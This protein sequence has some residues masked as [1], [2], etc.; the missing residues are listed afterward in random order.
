AKLSSSFQKR[1]LL[2]PTNTTPPGAVGLSE[3]AA[4]N[5]AIASA[6]RPTFFSASFAT[7]GV[8]SIPN[9]VSSNTHR[10]MMKSPEI[11]NLSAWTEVPYNAWFAPAPADSPASRKD[12]PTDARIRYRHQRSPR[13]QPPRC[14]RAASPE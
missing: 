3:S 12:A 6:Q 10:N 5:L 7:P 14:G 1:M 8:D 13:T 11:Q 4:V 2:L 9:A